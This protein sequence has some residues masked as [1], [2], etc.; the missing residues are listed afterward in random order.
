MNLLWI[1]FGGLFV[2]LGYISGGIALCLTVVGI[3]WGLQLFKLG[4]LSLFPFGSEVV[5]R[6]P[7]ATP[8]SGLN[9]LLNII[10]LIF[11]GIFVMLNHLV[12]G[13]VLCLTIIGIPF[14]MQHFKLMKLAFTPFGRTIID[15][16]ILGETR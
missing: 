6:Y 2:C 8:A 11:G 9:L 5:T 3:P 15:S 16:P 10:W 14:G 7:E 1:L 4:L 13:V 12:W